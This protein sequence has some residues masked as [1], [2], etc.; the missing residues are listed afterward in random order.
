MKRSRLAALLLAAALAAMTPL[1]ALA[2]GT[3]VCADITNTATLTYEVGTVPQPNKSAAS[4]P[5]DVASKVDLTVITED[6]A[7]GITVV[8]GTGTLQAVLE[9]TVTNTGNT[10]QDYILSTVDKVG[11]THAVWAPGDSADTF[12]AAG[13]VVVVESG[14]AAGY[15]ALDVATYIDELAPDAPKTVYIVATGTPAIAVALANG[16]KAVYA[17]VANSAAGGATGVL[18]A[19]TTNASTYNG[20][21][22]T[23]P[24]PVVLAD[25]AGTG[26][27]DISLDGADSAYSVF[28]VSSAD[29]SVN[30]VATTLWDPINYDTTPKAI[31]GAIV[32]YVVTITNAA[33]APSSATLTSIG[34]TLIASL[35]MDPDLL[36]DFTTPAT[37]AAESAA[38]SGFK[39]SV[40][41]TRVG[42]AGSGLAANVAK[43]YTTT[44][45]ADGVDLAGQSITATLATLLP[46]EAGY[47]V[48]ELKPGE[49]F[50]LTFNVI[51]Q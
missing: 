14:D 26:P 35:A 16:S 8:P 12:S 28:V 20:A 27:E 21:G 45:T 50:T 41:G 47:T 24:V 18:G 31:P 30:K 9:F 39:A 22:C 17:L 11:G 3:P 2:A 6:A 37:P 44:S 49:V 25:I 38:G 34:D 1:S 48:G 32:Q 33:L 46:A 40:T 23:A 51:I 5:F 10:V 42:N 7:P 43:Y 36:T 19:E 29:I 4:T 15:D 13:V